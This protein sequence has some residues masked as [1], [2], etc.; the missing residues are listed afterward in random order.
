MSMVYVS[1]EAMLMSM[2]CTDAKDHEGVHA[3][4][5]SCVDVCGLSSHCSKIRA[6]DGGHLDICGVF[7]CKSSCCCPWP[8]LP[9]ETMLK[10]VP[11]A[12]T[13]SHMDVCHP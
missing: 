10:S 3:S 9:P 4:A 8:A 11:C 7:S 12:N 13:R 5:K 2:A 1:P 6:V